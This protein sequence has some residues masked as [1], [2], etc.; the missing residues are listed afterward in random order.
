MLSRRILRSL[1]VV[2]DDRVQR[3]V[4]VGGLTSSASSMSSSLVRPIDALLLL[5]RQRVPGG[6][7]VQVLLHD[8]VAAAG[9]LRVLVADQRRAAARPGRVLGA[10][11]E[12]EQVALVEVRNP[13]TSSTTST[14]SPSRSMI[15][16]ASS[17]HRSMRSARMWNS[18]SPGV[19]TAR[20]PGSGAA[21]GTGAARPGAARRT[22]GP[23]ASE[24][25]PA[26]HVQPAAGT[27]KPTERS[28]PA[29]SPSSVADAS[30]PPSPDG[31]D[32]EDRGRR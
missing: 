30:S 9:E 27:R 21:R 32:Q 28:R 3:D 12:A 20:W 14:A 19:A 17:K 23:T 4:R 7:V 26:T 16:V 5:D 25:M 15:C 1:A 29:R 31:D 24:P 11:D 2:V 18:R 13:C 8:H 10:V 6:Q 22:A